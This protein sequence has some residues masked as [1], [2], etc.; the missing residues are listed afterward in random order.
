MDGGVVA[1]SD[2]QRRMSMR[3]ST[4]M[5]GL[6]DRGIQERADRFPF[7]QYGWTPRRVGELRNDPHHL[8]SLERSRKG[9]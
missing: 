9:G 4:S 1:H 7:V 6:A 8:G 5:L 2:V 3:G